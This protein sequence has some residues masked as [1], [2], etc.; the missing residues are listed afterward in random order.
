[1]SSGRL[2]LAVTALLIFQ[3]AGEVAVQALSLPVPGPV[4]GMFLLYAALTAR[5]SAPRA[6]TRAANGLL[7]QLS[8]LFVPAGVGIMAHLALLQREWPAIA[9]TLLVGTTLTLLVTAF[10]MRWLVT[11]GGSPSPARGR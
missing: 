6:L 3:L 1:M 4:V 9:V 8:L 7:S 11:R 10:W 2:L 5:G